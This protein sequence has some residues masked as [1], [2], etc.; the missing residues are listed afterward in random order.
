MAAFL[1][2]SQYVKTSAAVAS[3]GEFAFLLVSSQSSA[4]A[5]VASMVPTRAVAAKSLLRLD[6]GGFGFDRIGFLCYHTSWY[7]QVFGF[8]AIG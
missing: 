3:S 8:W 4:Q 1:L 5:V 6:M 2:A 7:C